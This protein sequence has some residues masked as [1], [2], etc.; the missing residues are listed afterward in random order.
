MIE[1]LGIGVASK[2]GGWLLRQVCVELETPSLT[3]VLGS[4]PD[5]RRALLDVVGARIIP[6]E[7]RAWLDHVPLMR[8]TRQ[9]LR[10]RAVA[11]EA[12]ASRGGLLRGALDGLRE[13]CAVDGRVRSLLVHELDTRLE[14]ADFAETERTL[15]A[16]V[17]VDRLSVFLSMPS[18]GALFAVADRLL[19][20][21]GG[22]L[23]FDG[24]PSRA[25]Q[26]AVPLHE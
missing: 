19:A 23:V 7:G 24:A 6:D 18:A 16:L 17:D 8:D 26:A 4:A 14:G 12:S 3:V 15:R 25:P 22:R 11:V 21:A 1:L 13:R 20:I 5:E 2:H 9:R 10:A